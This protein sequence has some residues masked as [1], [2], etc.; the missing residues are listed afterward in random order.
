MNKPLKYVR[1]PE[2]AMAI[3]YTGKNGAKVLNWA[4]KSL[5][6][7][8]DFDGGEYLQFYAAGRLYI[9]TTGEWV[10]KT[11]GEFGYQ[12]LPNHI[13]QKTYRRKLL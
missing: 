9:V 7:K 3:R 4:E 2:P 1:N 5:G 8:T 6:E 13:F 12:V 10:V 11:K